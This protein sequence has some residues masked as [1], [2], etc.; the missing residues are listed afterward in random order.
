MTPKDEKNLETLQSQIGHEFKD[1]SLLLVAITHRSF[2]R[3]ER[4]KDNIVAQNERLEFLGDAILSM[5]S[6]HEL[7]TDSPKADEGT[8][9]QLRAN[10]VCESHLAECG[11]QIGLGKIL[12]VAASMRKTEGVELPSI[13]SDAVEAIIGAVYLDAGL[14]PARETI[15]KILGPVPKKLIAAPKDPKT[16]LQEWTQARLG[17]TPI[18]EVTKSSGPPH[19]PIFVVEVSVKGRLLAQGQGPSKKEAAQEAARIAL[20]DIE[21]ASK[22]N[23]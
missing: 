7:F 3:D 9:T 10:Y 16:Q 15:R 19:M 18:Y 23:A 1:R 6:A 8:L 21:K 4:L 13:V 17:S 22:S 20:A 12:R 11:K 5:V 14:K 2:A